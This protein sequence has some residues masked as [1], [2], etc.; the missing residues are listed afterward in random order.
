MHSIGTYRGPDALPAV[1][2]MPTGVPGLDD[3]L[4]GGL[5]AG[6]TCLIAGEP[7]TG[8]TTLG[9]QIAFRHAAAGGSVVIATLLTEPHEL[10]LQNMSGFRFFH[11]RLTGDRIRYLNLLQPLEEQ[12]LEGVLQGVRQEIREASATLLVVDGA[13]VVEDMLVSKLDLRE[14]VQRLETQAA[15]LGCTMVIMTGHNPDTIRPLAAHVNGVLLLTNE[16]ISARHVRMLEVAKL[17]GGHHAGGVHEFAITQEGV[18]VYPRLESLVGQSRPPETQNHRMGTGIKGLDSMIQGGLRPL[19]STLVVGTP[20]AGKTLLGLSYIAEGARNNER[21]LIVEFHESPES[22][23]TTADGIGLDFSRHVDEGHIRILW[24]PPVEVSVDAWAWHVL[25]AIDQHR[26]M[27]VFID[28]IVDIQRHMP[29]PRR[30]PSYVSALINEIR[31][32]GATA[33]IAAEIDA[34]VDPRLA[35]PIPA[36]SA[37]MDNGILLR[38][39]EIDSEIRRMVSVLKARQIS[40]D[41]A[42][43]EFCVDDS[44]I[45]VGGPFTGATSLLTGDT[46]SVTRVQSDPS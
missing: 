35:V 42:I 32:R 1:T 11:P 19:S 18:H 15:S 37:T 30:M 33:M 28:G 10:M 43:R 24:N 29:D 6:R 40:I 41:P 23:A 4:G 9:N 12:G 25:S 20:G 7:G 36:I 46:T 27:R 22:L 3:V 2:R 31:A 38:Q 5:P 45:S 16:R 13:A 17:R 26:P 8:K 14:I 44:G 39:I 34:Y 21:G